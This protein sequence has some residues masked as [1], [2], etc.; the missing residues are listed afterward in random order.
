MKPDRCEVCGARLK[1]P[2][3]PKKSKEERCPDCGGIIPEKKVA[4]TLA[5]EALE[6]QGNEE[7][8][9]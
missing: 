6:G 5:E 3:I 4:E 7:A 1:G 9:K 8:Q 2:K